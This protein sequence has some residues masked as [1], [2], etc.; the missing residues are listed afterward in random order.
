MPQ[1][2]S[3]QNSNYICTC[4]DFTSKKKKIN[5]H[6][7][8]FPAQSLKDWFESLIIEFYC[9]YK[10]EPGK[11]TANQHIKKKCQKKNTLRPF[12]VV[13]PKFNN[14]TSAIRQ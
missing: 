13:Y 4:L 11:H 14:I 9:L 10:A 12:A 3:K 8:R 1:F 5:P 6:D 7:D 2:C